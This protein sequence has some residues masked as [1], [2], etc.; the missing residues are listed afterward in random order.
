MDS[1]FDHALNQVAD[2]AV[3]LS[4]KLL[5]TLSSPTRAETE[6]FAA[7]CASLDAARKREMFMR[8]VEYAEENF[9]LDF[10]DLFRASL[11]DAD[12]TVRRLAIEG[13]WEDERTD[14]VQRLL[15]MLA[16]DP[17][18]QVRAAAASSLGRF[19]FKAECEELDE[20]YGRLIRERLES[21]IADL[22]EDLDVRRRAVESIA[23]INDDKVRVIIDR[24]YDDDDHRMRESAVFAMGRNADPFWQETV[25]AELY[26]ASPAMRYEA[27]R[28]SGEMSLRRAVTRLIRLIEDVD[29]EVRQMAIWALG[30]IGGKRAKATLERYLESDDDAIVDA[31]EEALSELEFSNGSWDMMVHEFADSD[32]VEVDAL[33]D[34]EDEFDD[35]EDEEDDSWGDDYLDI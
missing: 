9:E 6:R 33:E 29:V 31:A 18:A 7:L 19:L 24:T 3:Q 21:V 12:A 34:D 22:N 1:E 26:A 30:Q 13:L 8:M 15:H 10:V 25:L 11:E 28:A 27:A 23:Y 5:A 17:E 32:L 20:R 14:L 2:N 4:R 35:L 16:N